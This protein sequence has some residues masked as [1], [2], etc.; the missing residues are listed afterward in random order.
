[1]SGKRSVRPRPR[2]SASSAVH[3]GFAWNIQ[4]R[5]ADFLDPDLVGFGRIWSDFPCNFQAVFRP[6][7]S[8]LATNLDP[9]LSGFIILIH[10]ERPP[11][12]FHPAPVEQILPSAR[13]NAP[14]TKPHPTPRA[15][16]PSTKSA[17]TLNG[18]IFNVSLQQTAQ[19]AGS[20]SP[21]CTLGFYQIAPLFVEPIPDASNDSGWIG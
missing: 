2:P 21:R 12:V 16:A 4:P 3:P 19:P 8:G 13:K 5:P 18:M 7:P 17:S 15:P 11:A 6:P 20:F 9:L 14:S 10:K 1:M